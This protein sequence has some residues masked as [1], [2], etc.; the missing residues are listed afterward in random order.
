MSETVIRPIVL[1]IFRRGEEILVGKGYDPA[2][3]QRFYRPP[4]G[5]IEFGEYGE[6]AL[7]REMEEE[8]GVTITD[9]RYLGTL[10][11]IFTFNGRQGH[12]FVQ[13]YEATSV[14]PAFYEKNVVE[15][16]EEA[17][18]PY[19]AV[20]KSLDE[21]QKGEEVLVPLTLLPLLMASSGTDQQEQQEK[22][23]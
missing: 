5:G 21:F 6:D 3:Q 1:A 23:Q 2:T 18:G 4:G 12:E 13:V 8:L 17:I 11:N 20:W 16:Y 19:E 15:A 9:V 10:E 22:P 14:D 7:K